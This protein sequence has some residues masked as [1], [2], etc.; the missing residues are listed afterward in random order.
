MFQ[1]PDLVR[2]AIADSCLHLGIAIATGIK[3]MENPTLQS[4][5][6]SV[7]VSLPTVLCVRLCLPT[8]CFC[9]SV[10]P[11]QLFLFHRRNMIF[12]LCGILHH[13]FRRLIAALHA[14]ML[15]ALR[16]ERP[17]H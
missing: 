7:C 16:S 9:P 1:A 13:P 17:E 4:V 8:N 12:S 5:R 15:S 2:G 3:L 11:Y 14:L 10:S 6:P